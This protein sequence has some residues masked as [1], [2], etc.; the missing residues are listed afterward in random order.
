MCNYLV[1]FVVMPHANLVRH[2]YLTTRLRVCR[3]RPLARALWLA[4]QTTSATL[5]PTTG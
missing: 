2:D 1:R 5:A 3:L 4:W